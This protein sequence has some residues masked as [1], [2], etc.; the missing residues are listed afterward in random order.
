MGA[1]RPKYRGRL[2]ETNPIG[3]AKAMGVGDAD[4][5]FTPYGGPPP[6]PRPEVRFGAIG[7][8]WRLLLDRWGTWVLAS[9][10]VLAGNSA[11]NALLVALMG[12]KFEIRGDGFRFDLPP[13]GRL[14]DAVLSAVLNGFLIGGIVRMAC[15]QVRGLPFSVGDLFGNG[16]DLVQLALGA[17]IFAAATFA[18]G[19]FCLVGALLAAGLLMFTIPLIVDGRLAATDA[20]AASWNALKG[21]WLSASVF[22]LLATAVSGLGACCCVGLPFTMPLY[23]LSIAVLYRDFFP[24]R[25]A[26]PSAK[27]PG[28]DP[29]R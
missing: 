24:A 2:G 21:R 26:S 27:P 6:G 11:I 13:G 17:A 25:D 22:H 18:G 3:G 20:A 16:D 5:D 28:V 10:I 9:L 1:G 29:Y 23:G 14:L 19:L 15:R 4:L 8:A 12:G 7:A